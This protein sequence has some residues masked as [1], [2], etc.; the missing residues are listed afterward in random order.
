[1]IFLH[2]P[3]LRGLA[4]TSSLIIFAIAII[5][6]V[7]IKKDLKVMI[8]GTTFCDIEKHAATSPIGVK[9]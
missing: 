3:C 8:K 1:V 6:S 2:H 5:T 7:E 4:K 9:I